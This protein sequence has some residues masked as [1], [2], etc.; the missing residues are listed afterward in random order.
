[1]RA[2]IWSG[3]GFEAAGR[4]RA[5]GAS[6]VTGGRFVFDCCASAPDNVATAIRLATA[7]TFRPEWFSNVSLIE[8]NAAY[9]RNELGIFAVFILNAPLDQNSI[10]STPHQR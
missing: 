10:C 7:E 6:T 5:T 8:F 9:E 1:L 3:V 4:G 2:W